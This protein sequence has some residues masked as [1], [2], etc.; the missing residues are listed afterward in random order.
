MRY[1]NREPLHAKKP[2]P[3]KT[4]AILTLLSC[5]VLGSALAAADL[6]DGY[7]VVVKFQLYEATPGEASNDGFASDQIWATQPF[8][9]LPAVPG[10]LGDLSSS[11]NTYR[12]FF[13]PI[14]LRKLTGVFV[15]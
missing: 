14:P 11:K 7:R 8:N 13:A 3:L 10:E 12:L 1:S 5:L 6:D 15:I 9:R 4:A 2:N